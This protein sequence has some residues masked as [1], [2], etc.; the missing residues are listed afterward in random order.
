MMPPEEAP[1][2]RDPQVLHQV[3]DG[4]AME[5]AKLVDGQQ[6]LI[7]MSNYLSGE[8]LAL[9][10]ILTA[11]R[12]KSGLSVTTDEAMESFQALLRPEAKEHGAEI[13][14]VIRIEIHR[15]LKA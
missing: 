1:D 14:D 7:K 15:L 10:A 3:F 5:I 13:S 6:K 11:M 4:F 2:L 9:S 12:K 8:N